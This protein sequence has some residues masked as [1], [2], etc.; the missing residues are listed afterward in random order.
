MYHFNTAIKNQIDDTEI[1]F[2]SGWITAGFSLGGIPG[3]FFWGW[4]SDRYGRRLAIILGIC[5]AFISIN[6]FGLASNFWVALLG[7]V[8][9]GFLNGNLGVSKTYISE[10]C[11]D[12]TQNFG[13]TLFTCVG[14]IAT[15][16]ISSS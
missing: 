8:M 14:G 16:V 13:F 7:R 3:N 10:I 12:Y 11:N 6:V 15:F 9:W 2:Y 4:F 1:G 5:G